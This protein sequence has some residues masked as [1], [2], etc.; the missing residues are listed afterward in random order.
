MYKKMKSGSDLKAIKKQGLNRK[1]SP[2]RMDSLFCDI[3][4]GLSVQCFRTGYNF[5]NLSCNCS[6]TRFVV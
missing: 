6:L 3:L 4:G 1:G 5:K 2:F